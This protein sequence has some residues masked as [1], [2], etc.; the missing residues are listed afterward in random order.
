M[1]KA[2]TTKLLQ[3]V[4]G[5]NLWHLA[6]WTIL[7]VIL[8]AIVVQLIVVLLA[9]LYSVQYLLMTALLLYGVSRWQKRSHHKR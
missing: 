9:A 4:Q 3:A 7:S 2:P 6:G 8:L 5:S 1:L